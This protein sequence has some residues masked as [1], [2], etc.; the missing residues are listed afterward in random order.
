MARYWTC[1]KCGLRWGRTKQRCD[2]GRARPKART[3][4]HRAILTEMPYEDWVARYGACCGVCGTV[5]NGRR[6][7]RDH[8]HATG[9]P[10]GLLCH[11]C[12]RAL[13]S[14]VTTE[15]LERARGYLQDAGGVRP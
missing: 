4:A 1:R 9:R 14:W 3:A 11:R 10:R 13:P 2:C 5:P 6:L 12:N 15:W 8:D 7:D